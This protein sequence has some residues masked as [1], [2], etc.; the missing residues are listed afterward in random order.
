MTK[1]LVHWPI[2]PREASWSAAALRRFARSNIRTALAHRSR[3]SH[4]FHEDSPP[5]RMEALKKLGSAPAPGV[6]ADAPVRRRER[7]R[8]SRS[9]PSP[10]GASDH[11]PG[12]TS[13]ALGSRSLKSLSLLA[14]PNGGEG[15]GGEV[16]RHAVTRPH[17]PP[18]VPSRILALG[19]CLPCRFRFPVFCSL[20]SKFLLLVLPSP[21]PAAI[22]IP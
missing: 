12:Q 11:G 1:P 17:P 15:R 22:R 16:A 19:I 5:R 4:F 9:S 7:I 13:V 20:L 10:G 8:A 14:I 2:R 3:P 18:A 21:S 6:A